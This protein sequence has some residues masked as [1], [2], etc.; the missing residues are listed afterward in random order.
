M[1]TDSESDLLGIKGFLVDL[2]GV[3]YVGDEV[4]AG[5]AD[6]LRRIKDAGYPIRG[7]TNTTTKSAA[8]LASRL[9]SLNLPLGRDEIVTAPRLAARYLRARG[10]P[11]VRL[12][13]SDDAAREFE[14]FEEV[15]DR[16]EA[17]VIGD[18]GEKWDY[19]LMTELFDALISGA[20]LIALHKGRYYQG[21]DG[22]VLD[23]GAF[24]SGLEYAA[25]VEAVVIG[26]PSPRFFEIA[27]ESMG[28][29]PD[30]AVMVGDDIESDV[31]GAQAAGLKGVLVRTGK[32]REHLVRSSSVKPDAILDSIADLPT[33]LRSAHGA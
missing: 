1:R 21:P 17:I 7:V 18:V 33:L 26:K 25:G 11:K 14:E 23:I 27:V 15:V 28:V 8:T 6:A 20:D 2:D 22:L 3:L 10:N 4:I 9:Q 13:L 29:E 32:F 31:G 24:V 30:R 16:P 12:V 5:A 19:A